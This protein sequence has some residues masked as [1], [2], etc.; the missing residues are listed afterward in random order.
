M[1]LEGQK[2]ST[3]RNWAIWAKDLA[4]AYQPDAIRYFFLANGPEKRDA[5]FAFREFQ[6]QVNTE[7]VG[8][9]GN[10][11]NRTLAFAAKYQGGVLESVEPDPSLREKVAALYEAVGVAIEKGAFRDALG[12]IFEAVRFGK[13]YY[14]ARQP[15]KTR[16][17]DAVICRDT[18]A[19]CAY[20]IANLAN[21][22]HPF[23][24]FSSEQVAQ[25]LG[26]SFAW[27]EQRVLAKRIP[28]NIP[29]LYLKIQDTA[30]AQDTYS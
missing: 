20:W 4:D 21:L 8:A 9:W 12:T 3:S 18:I 26:I 7:L 25:W 29:R 15:W 27:R 2:I 22:L 24:P 10:L 16:T 5:D 11:V 28:E 14:D 30:S 23:L 17:S 19:Q 1:T 6:K 13:V